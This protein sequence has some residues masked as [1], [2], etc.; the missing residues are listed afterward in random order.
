[1]LFKKKKKKSLNVPFCSVSCIKTLVNWS[2]QVAKKIFVLLFYRPCTT[3]KFHWHNWWLALW[4]VCV[5]TY[6]KS[7]ANNIVQQEI[8]ILI[9]LNI[10]NQNTSASF[11][12][13]F[14]SSRKDSRCG[15]AFT[16]EISRSLSFDF[17]VGQ[18]N[19]LTVLLS[20]QI[21]TWSYRIIVT[22]GMSKH[23]EFC[24]IFLG[25]IF[26]LFFC[27]LLKNLSKDCEESLK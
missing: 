13:M 3:L 7:L 16:S 20:V 9:H 27:N 22:L 5:T 15:F 6:P 14:Y 11:I 26:H 19:D 4:S 12:V 18:S 10:M 23:R 2:H 1:M 25:H 24:G 17:S 21:Y 8:P